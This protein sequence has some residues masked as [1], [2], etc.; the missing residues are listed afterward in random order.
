MLEMEISV[1][2]WEVWVL[3][4]EIPV[5]ELG[6]GGSVPEMGHFGGSDLNTDQL[7][8]TPLDLGLFKAIWGNH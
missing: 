6:G 3:E 5:M 1:T 2:R 7:H 4:M 8:Q